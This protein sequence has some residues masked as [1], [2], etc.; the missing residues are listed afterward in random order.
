MHGLFVYVQYW[1][2]GFLSPP[3][4]EFSVVVDLD[5]SHLD[6]DTIPPEI[7]I[8]TS[9][10]TLS[11]A[12]NDI[13]EIPGCIFD[14]M[15]VLEVLDLSHNAIATLPRQIAANNSIMTFL[16]SSG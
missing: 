11:F 2:D 16:H 7:C 5:M 9:L 13:T 14:S 10:V 1:Y 8:F 12:H 3:S 15:P 6:L 4:C